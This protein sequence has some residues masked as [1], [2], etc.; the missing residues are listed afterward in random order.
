MAG[1]LSIG[2]TGDMRALLL[3]A[4]LGCTSYGSASA[5]HE[6]L[7]GLGEALDATSNETD[8]ERALRRHRQEEPEADVTWA[9]QRRPAPTD[10]ARPPEGPP[11]GEP[12]PLHDGVE[13]T[14]LSCT[15][16]AQCVRTAPRTCGCRAGQPAVAVHLQHAD[17]VARRLDE[18]LERCSPTL[19]H[20][21]CRAVPRCHDGL[22]RLFLP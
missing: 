20:V 1:A 7:Q 21:T 15:E 4:L 5:G 14:E 13:S 18:A 11:P 3:M 16:D 12:F 10:E 6:L 17:T 9:T 2:F 22:C 19:P 8:T